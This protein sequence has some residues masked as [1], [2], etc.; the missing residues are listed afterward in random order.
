MSSSPHARPRVGK[1]GSRSPNCCRG[2]TGSTQASM[3]RAVRCWRAR[4]VERGDPN[5]VDHARLAVG[6]DQRRPPEGR[7]FPRTGPGAR[8][9]RPARQR[10]GIIS[11]GRVSSRADCGL[12]PPSRGRG[13]RRQHR[14]SRALR[15]GEVT[16]CTGSHRWTDALASERTGYLP[17]AIRLYEQLGSNITALRLRA[18]IAKNDAERAQVR[19]DM[20][21]LL[22]KLSV[23]QVPARPQ[24]ARCRAGASLPRRRADRRRAAP[25]PRACSSAPRAATRGSTRIGHARRR[26]P[27]HLWLG[28]RAAGPPS[29]CHRAVRPGDERTPARGSAVP[30]RPRPLSH[31]GRRG[32]PCRAPRRA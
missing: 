26:R 2:A 7:A 18:I 4:L 31:P 27:D 24:R 19:R 32:G 10:R 23:A 3:A 15:A 9:G 17:R 6:I 8:P 12:A 1:G 11:P 20:I 21:A 14:T 13:A 25:P 29:R 30:T 28:A 22:P 16:R 5:A